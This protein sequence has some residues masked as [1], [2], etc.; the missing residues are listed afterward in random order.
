VSEDVKNL[1]GRS[2]PET[3]PDPL[4][5]P[6]PDRLYAYQAEELTPAE[7]LEIQEHLAVCSHC[8]ELLLDVQSFSMPSTQ[9]EAGLSEF[10]QAA[11]WRTLR[12]RLDQDGFF[13]RGRRPRHRVAAV[14]AL[15]L[16][17]VVGLSIYTL[18]REAPEV[19][20]LD[21]LESHRGGPSEVESVRLPV[22]LV[23]RS[24]SEISYPE[25]QAEIHDLAGR[26]VRSVSGLRQNKTF[27]VGLKLGRADLPPGE[28]RVTL[29][30]LRNGRTEIAEYSLRI[31]KLE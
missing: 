10:E 6:D 29:L 19:R 20:T 4:E 31:Q 13:T 1:G 26:T 24:P 21:P 22:L 12:A 27:E 3:L 5:H 2:S 15:F 30:G 9:E 7:E 25:Y 11:G 23:L 18:T 8:T 17:A 28:Y 16:L 14:A